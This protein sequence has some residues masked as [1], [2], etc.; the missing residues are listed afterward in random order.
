MSGSTS[1]DI[2]ISF[3]IKELRIFV[4]QK[5]GHFGHGSISLTIALS[6]SKGIF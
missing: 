2:Y 4:P 1:P 5:I 6:L 3:E